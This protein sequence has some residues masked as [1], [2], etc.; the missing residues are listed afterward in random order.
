MEINLIKFQLCKE[1][2]PLMY[3]PSQ[4]RIL[5]MRGQRYRHLTNPLQN[6]T[7]ILRSKTGRNL[8]RPCKII[9]KRSKDLQS[10]HQHSNWTKRGKLGRTP[11]KG[12]NLTQASSPPTGK[13]SDQAIEL[14]SP[15]ETKNKYQILKKME[16]EEATPVKEK[17]KKKTFKKPP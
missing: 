11:Q 16:T 15:T 5:G 3:R 2:S 6:C 9:L 10:A 12:N 1:K 17:N 4:E 14:T 8:L 13:I 7:L